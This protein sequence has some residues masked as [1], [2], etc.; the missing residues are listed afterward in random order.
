M[1]LTLGTRQELG[2]SWVVPQLDA[3]AERFPTVQLHLYFGSG[4]DLLLRV[5][6]MEID[7]AIT[8]THFADPKL[9]SVQI[10]REEYVFVGAPSLLGSRPLRRPADAGAH[11]LLDATADLPLFRYWRDAPGGGDVLSFGRIVRLGSIAAIR[12]RLLEGAGVGVVPR[13]LVRSDLTARRLRVVFPRVT[14]LHDWFRLIFRA[15]DPRRAVYS[16][17][18]AAMREMPLR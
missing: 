5:R 8:S 12:Q 2:L 1:E 16:P 13:Y 11:T 18:A 4:D 10:H 14:P 17:L 7:C 6:T 3:L 15:D 9:E